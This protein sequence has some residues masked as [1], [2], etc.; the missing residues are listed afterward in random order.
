MAAEWYENASQVVRINVL[1]VTVRARDVPCR[2]RRS[3]T[4]R[5]RCQ[6]CPKQVYHLY[7]E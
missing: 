5:A 3:G 7:D 2:R 6:V 1:H 4:V